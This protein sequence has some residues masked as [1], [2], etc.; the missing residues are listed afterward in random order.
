MGIGFLAVAVGVASM[1]AAAGVSGLLGAGLGVVML[2][3]AVNDARGFI[4]P[5][6]LTGL[7]FVLG[8]LDA[9]LKEGD[10][11]ASLIGSL[12][13]ASVLALCFLA[14][15]QAY[16]RLR[17]RHG[18]GLGDV[19]LAGASGPWLT[20]TMIPISI[21]IAA[22]AGLGTYAV[23]Q[24]IRG[25]PMRASG[26]LPFGTFYAPAIWLCWMIEVLAFGD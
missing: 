15:R 6:F 2:A 20:W 10:V 1:S 12:M 5:D 25:A 7:A 8:L 24:L 18:L 4:I 17:G 21:E 22:F 13:R 3:V 11:A 16:Y 9:A 14:L 26:V 23:H 19:K